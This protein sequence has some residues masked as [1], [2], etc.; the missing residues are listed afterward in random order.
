MES[1][2]R[3]LGPNETRLVLSLTEENREIVSA[4]EIIKLLGSETTARTV[5]RNLLRKG[6]LTRLVGGRYMLLPPS[7]GPE[8]LGEN[9][10][11]AL[12]SAAVEPS[13]V[14][15]WAA[16]SFHGMTTQRPR[17][18]AVAVLKQRGPVTIEGHQVRFVRVAERKFFGYADFE[19]Y[20]RTARISRAAKT[21]VDC[22]DRPAL[23]GGAAEVA[24]IVFA[25]SRSVDPAELISDALRMQSQSL[26]QRLGFL[27][28]LVDCPLP[29]AERAAIRDAIAPS[30]R[31]TFG[32]RERHKDDIG[33]VRDWGLFVHAAQ[34]DLL[35]D[36]PRRMP[37]VH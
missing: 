5:I 11:L 28:D 15:W 8:N 23:A 30:A 13:Y 14:S 3:T 7:H 18:T 1:N 21:I 31:S 36:V 16:A 19:I 17:I 33:Y 4:A 26:L 10:V 35:A 25:G 37:D 6:W 34:R 24:R 20:G 12:A 9:N 27:T 29:D 32:R 22:I 2:L